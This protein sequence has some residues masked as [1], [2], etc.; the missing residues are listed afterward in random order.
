MATLTEPTSPGR[1]IGIVCGLQ[2]EADW[3]DAAWSA[4]AGH[5]ELVVAGMGPARSAEAATR[6]VATGIH[7]LVSWGSAA[8]LDPTLE[9][10]T[11][12]L[13]ERI[14][15]DAGPPLE[16]HR[17]WLSAIMEALVP[18]VPHRSGDL[19][20]TPKVLADPAAKIELGR[21][22]G[23]VAADMESAAVAR[24]A[25]EAGVPWI[26]VRAIADPAGQA[27][28]AAVLD[29]VG[30]DGV[31]DPAAVIRSAATSLSG[32]RSLLRLRH[33]HMAAARSMRRLARRTGPLLT[34]PT[35][36]RRSISVP[37]PR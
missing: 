10:G 37:E 8:G 21:R 12:I 16:A 29:A 26:A 32:I 19:A 27:L 17:P 9:P 3:L 14:L 31:I 25:I 28:P 30:E 1:K 36:S 33:Q 35:G 15:P 5:V 20:E 2:L 11:V 24:V 7:G 13:P 4:M 18:T 23:A 22:T 34:A 6:L